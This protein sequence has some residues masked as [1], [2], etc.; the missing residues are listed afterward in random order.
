MVTLAGRAQS[1]QLLAGLG[2]AGVEQPLGGRYSCSPMLSPPISTS[3]RPVCS[4][5]GS[6]CS[7]RPPPGEAPGGRAQGRSKRSRFMT[8]SH[9]ATK[10]CT[11]FSLRVVAGVDLGDGSELGVRPEDEV[12][13]GAGPLELAG[14]AVAALVDVLGREDACH[15]VPMSSRF[16]KKSLVSVPGRS[17]KTPCLICPA[18]ASERP[19][20]ADE[21]R[22]L[23]GGQGQQAGP[24]DQQLLGPAFL[25]GPEVVPEPVGRR[26]EHGERRRRRS[27]PARRRCARVRTGPARRAR[28]PARPARRPRTRRGRSGRR[29]TPSSRR[30]ASC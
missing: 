22:H 5:G 20:A 1:L 25:P 7:G 12:D 16:T 19:Q 15:S 24:V 11:N 10:S 14:R 8:L 6:R 23:R 26:L 18:L 4:R 17:V 27:A 29:A 13:R 3:R 21:H 30:T 2:H 9:A 28:R